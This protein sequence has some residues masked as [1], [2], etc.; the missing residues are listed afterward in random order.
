M[1]HE[2]RALV[3]KGLENRTAWLAQR[4]KG[5]DGREKGWDGGCGWSSSGGD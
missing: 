4:G 3:L 1:V 2:A 5:V